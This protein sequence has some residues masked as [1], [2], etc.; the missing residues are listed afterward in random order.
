MLFLVLVVGAVGFRFLGQKL[1]GG[2]GKAGSN[3]DSP[4]PVAA[5][6][7]SNGTGGNLTTSHGAK[8]GGGAAGGGD[9][10]TGYG[11]ARTPIAPPPE[12]SPFAKFAM[13]ALGII[14]CGA[15][16]F[17]AMKGKHAR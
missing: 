13:I 8:G 15:A 10:N 14:G 12:G 3:L 1:G 6:A 9:P 2:V 11:G 7:D 16:F 17:A 4:T 5:Q